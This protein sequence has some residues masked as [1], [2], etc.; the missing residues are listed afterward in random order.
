MKPKHGG[1]VLRFVLHLAFDGLEDDVWQVDAHHIQA[2]AGQLVHLP[3]HQPTAC[4]GF[5]LHDGVDSS[6]FFLEHDLL[7]ACR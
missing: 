5:V 4:A 7:V 2:V 6:A 1:D 3:P